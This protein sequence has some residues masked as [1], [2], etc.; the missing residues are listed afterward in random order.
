MF[1]YGQINTSHSFQICVFLWPLSADQ[2]LCHVTMLLWNSGS[3]GD[4]NFSSL[5]QAKDGLGTS[6]VGYYA[7]RRAFGVVLGRHAER[8]DRQQQGI[9]WLQG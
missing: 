8:R 9:S 7:Y 4:T 6:N 1:F 3:P 2:M 5:S